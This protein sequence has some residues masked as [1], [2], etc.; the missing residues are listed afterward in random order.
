MSRG[1]GLSSKACTPL[2]RPG[3]LIASIETSSGD[4]AAGFILP[5]TVIDEA[6]IMSIGVHLLYR[7]KGI[8]QT[9]VDAVIHAADPKAGGAVFLEVAEDNHAA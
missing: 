4:A 1:H 6:D 5:R 3:G 7:R 8:G 9:L 2:L